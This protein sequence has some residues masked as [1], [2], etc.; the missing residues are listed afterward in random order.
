MKTNNMEKLIKNGI[1]NCEGNY[2]FE[3]NCLEVARRIGCVVVFPKVNEIQIDID[4][5]KSLQHFKKRYKEFKKIWRVN[6]IHSSSKRRSSKSK[7]DHCH[8]SI[9]LETSIWDSDNVS[10]NRS[11]YILTEQQRILYQFALGSDPV[12]ET[13]NT[14]RLVAGITDPSRLFE[15]KTTE[16]NKE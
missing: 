12:R 10:F 3:E 7:G 11:P 8:I 5:R 13:L 6:G 4:S 2:S 14:M 16:C 9:F 15:E 1:D